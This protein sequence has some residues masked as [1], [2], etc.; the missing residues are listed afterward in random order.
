MTYK[1]SFVNHFHLFVP[2]TV[3]F[4]HC[5][6]NAWA[7][8]SNKYWWGQ[9]PRRQV[10]QQSHTS[11][12]QGE[13]NERKQ[14]C[15]FHTPYPFIIRKWKPV[16]CLLTSDKVRNT[17]GMHAPPDEASMVCF[18]FWIKWLTAK[19][20]AWSFHDIVKAG[21]KEKGGDSDRKASVAT[22]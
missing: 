22:A 21:K 19:F 8:L 13:K 5:L 16:E 12:M 14:R 20:S 4:C 1:T 9:N 6:L 11:S 17:G 10:L 18:G 3:K 7:A 2:Y 15:S